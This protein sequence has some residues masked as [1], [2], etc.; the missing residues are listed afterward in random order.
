MRL[1]LT[2]LVTLDGVVQAPGAPS[3]DPRDGFDHGGWQVP[4]VDD[5]HVEL[6]NT[7]FRRASA[8]LLGRR[9]YEVFAAHWPRVTDRHDFIARQLNSL[10]KYVVST[11][12]TSATWHD[13]TIIGADVVDAVAALKEQ[14]GG[15]LQVHGS[16]R[17]AHTLMAHDLV[18]E[19]RLLTYPVVLG[20]GLRLFDDPN[21]AALELIE[22]H[23]TRSGAILATY[24]PAGEPRYGSFALD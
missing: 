12:L 8:F 6:E 2:M 11:T 5:E 17:L 18:D 9:T 1:T 15:E 14:Q 24:R 3:E 21:A 19:Y 16:A 7:W 22:T 20:S 23:P 4:Y 10:P 13:T